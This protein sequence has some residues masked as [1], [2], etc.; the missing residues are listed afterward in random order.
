MDAEPVL[1]LIA[2][3]SPVRGFTFVGIGGRGGAG[4]STLAA[5]IEGAQIVS[6]DEFWD[7]EGFELSRLRAEVFDPL[8]TGREARYAS[9]DWAARH[10][11]GTRAIQP[12][13]VVVVEGVC[14]LHRMFRDDYDVRV[15]V[16]AP[17]ETRLARGVARDGEE[18]RATWVEQW[19]PGED[20]YVERDD[21]VSCADLVVDGSGP[22]DV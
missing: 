1:E 4:K 6:T 12:R 5:R 8:V 14:A 18:A 15:W 21:P 11:G 10:P 16:E 3:A 17:Y 20:R 13:G 9:W 7:G 2:A 19:M 22:L